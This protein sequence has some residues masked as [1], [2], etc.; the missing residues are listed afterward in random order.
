MSVHGDD[1]APR[2]E[3][4]DDV[5]GLGADAGEAHEVLPRLVEGLLHHVLEG[6]VETF[7]DLLRD[8]LEHLA[9]LV[10]HSG[11]PYGFSDGL[12]GGV[13]EV[14]GGYADH[15][16]EAVVCRGPVPAVGVLAQDR[17]H[18]GSEGVI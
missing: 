16:F 9:A 18:E 15:L 10:V 14:L 12:E 6:A 4:E 8:S 7:E 2:D 1:P 3:H 5:C 17:S 11:G 13:G